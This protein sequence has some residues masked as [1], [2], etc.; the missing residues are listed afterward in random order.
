MSMLIFYYYSGETSSNLL[1][2]QSPEKLHPMYLKIENSS[3]TPILG[4][5]N[6][7]ITVVEFGDYQCVHCADFNKNQKDS[8]IDNYTKSGIAK[9]LF[10]DFTV[11]D[12]QYGMSTLA[13]R[14]SYCAGDQG[15]YWQYHDTVFRNFD[16][17]PDGKIQRSDLDNYAKQL[18]A[19]DFVK[20][21][22]CLDSNKYLDKV[23]ENNHLARQ[24]N[25]IGTPTFL[26]YPSTEL[27]LGTIV[28]GVNN[29][30]QLEGIDLAKLV[31]G[32]TS[33]E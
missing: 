18:G 25:I 33:N 8:L 23:N 7:N 31:N 4:N 16:N 3:I 5:P 20:F 29:H 2:G 11:N 27:S 1:Y 17:R 22:N 19:L 15:K 12:G 28:T 14:A 24:L 10:K 6:A 13:A 32:E 30:T 9:F 21:K 26:V